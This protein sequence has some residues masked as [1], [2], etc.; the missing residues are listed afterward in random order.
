MSFGRNSKK[1]LVS[2]RILKLACLRVAV[3]QGYVSLQ[4]FTQK[5]F[6]ILVLV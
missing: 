1:L 2:E 3:D 5:S 4:L 6:N